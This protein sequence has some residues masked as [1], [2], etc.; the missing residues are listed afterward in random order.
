MKAAP[1]GR[2]VYRDLRSLED[3]QRLRVLADFAAA[4]QQSTHPTPYAAEIVDSKTGRRLVRQLNSCVKDED[5]TRHAE[6]GA[7]KVACRKKKAAN[8]AGYTLYS[9]CEPCPMC[10]GSILWARLDRIVYGATLD[11]AGQYGPQIYTYARQM[12]KSSDF[13]CEVTGPLE[14]ERCLELFR[15]PS[16]RY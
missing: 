2:T 15:L 10:M 11:D 8:L 6:L 1:R 12:V 9:T 14:R 4:S 7:I 3:A 5:P 16:R 13:K